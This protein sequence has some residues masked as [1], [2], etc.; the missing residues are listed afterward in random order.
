MRP[1][2]NCSLRPLLDLVDIRQVQ[3]KGAYLQVVCGNP[4]PNKH[5]N[6]QA[7]DEQDLVGEAVVAITAQCSGR[8]EMRGVCL[9]V[10]S[11][12][13]LSQNRFV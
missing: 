9:Q 7:V 12:G 5:G 11:S 1:D 10:A 13:S 4:A 3:S 6:N 8:R 2:D